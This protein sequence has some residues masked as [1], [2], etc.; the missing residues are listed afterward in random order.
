MYTG[1]KSSQLMC[2]SSYHSGLKQAIVDENKQHSMLVKELT[3]KQKLLKQKSIEKKAIENLKDRKKE[4]YYINL[5]DHL[6][7]ETEDIIIMRK[8][9]EIHK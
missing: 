5:S 1:I 4:E 8:V 9:R 2:Y 6:Q 7:K 3:H